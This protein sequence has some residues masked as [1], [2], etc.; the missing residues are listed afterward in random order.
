MLE[1]YLCTK[2]RDIPKDLAIAHACCPPA[3]PKHASTC[4]E[5]SYPL[6]Y[7]ELLF[8]DINFI[9]YFVT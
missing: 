6:A 4:L 5:V 2:T 8:L 9:K 1:D 7:I 3:P